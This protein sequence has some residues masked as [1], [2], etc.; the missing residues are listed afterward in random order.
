MHINMV[1]KAIEYYRAGTYVPAELTNRLINKAQLNKKEKLLVLF[2]YEMLP[3]LFELGFKNVT[4]LTDNPRKSIIE[5]VKLFG[6]KV[7]TEKELYKMNFDVAIGNPPF[8]A[9]GNKKTKRGRAINLYPKFYELSTNV[10]NKVAMIMP[11]TIKQNMIHNEYILK[12]ASRIEDVDNR[13]FPTVYMNMWVVYSGLEKKEELPEFDQFKDKPKQIVTWYKGKLNVTTDS[14]LLVRKTKNDD[15]DFV[16]YHKISDKTGLVTYYTNKQISKKKLFPSGGYAVLLPQQITKTGWSKSEIVK[17]NGLQAAM[18]GMT[19]VF[20]KTKS[21][22]ENL[23]KY[24][25]GKKFITQ[26]L[27]YCGG[28]NNMTLNALTSINMDDYA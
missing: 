11:K 10:A 22:A 14:N 18:N 6:Y 8:S 4:L 9:A 2:S 25:Q 21:E 5:I 17:C 28:M 23:I 26:A 1:K 24:M 27:S 19:I 12:T 7:I 3:V 13:N 16:I 20:T 15:N